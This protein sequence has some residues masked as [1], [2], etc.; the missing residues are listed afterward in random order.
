[1]AESISEMVPNS[2]AGDGT[3]TSLE[4]RVASVPASLETFRSGLFGLRTC[5]LSVVL[6]WNKDEM[7]EQG[8]ADSLSEGMLKVLVESEWLLSASN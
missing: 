5:K 4:L 2:S 6:F 7:P 1:M 8:L 3:F